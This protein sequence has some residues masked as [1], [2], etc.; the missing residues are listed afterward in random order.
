M[1]EVDDPI[2]YDQRELS[3]LWCRLITPLNID[4]FEGFK[5]AGMDLLRDHRDS[6]PPAYLRWIDAG[7]RAA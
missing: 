4:T 1:D 3:D 7:Y 2:P 6:F 5:A